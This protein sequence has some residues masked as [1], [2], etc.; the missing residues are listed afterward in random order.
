MEPIF[1]HTP[2]G[3][4]PMGE[5]VSFTLRPLRAEGFSAVFLT[6]SFEQDGGKNVSLPLPWTGLS[7]AHELFSASFPLP[8]D[9]TGLVWCSLTAARADGRATSFGPFQ[10]TVYDDSEAVPHW[11][12]RG[13][14]YQIFPDRFCRTAVPDPA[15]MPGGRTVH[16]NWSDLPDFLPNEQ[17]EVRNRDF[18]GGSLESI[19]RKIPYLKTLGVE[20]VYLC[21]IFEGAENHRYGTGDYEKIDPMLGTEEDFRA[22]C[23]ALHANGMKLLLDGVF[24]HTGFVSRYFNGDGS[25]PGLGAAQSQESSYY[26]WY[27]FTHWPD[28]YDSWWGVYSLPTV[29]K[30]EPT[31][32]DYIVRDKNSIARRWLRAGADGWRLDV[33][34]ELPDEF[35][36]ALH[37]AV[38]EE[39]P[40]AVLLGEVWEDGSNKIAYGV[41]RRHLWGRHL[42]G[43]MN[44]PLR[45]ALFAAIAE[46]D[47]SHLAQNEVLLAQNYP[48]F[49]RQNSMNFLG[50][51]DTVRVLSAMGALLT[52]PPEEKVPRANY[53][54]PPE[55]SASARA[56]VRI[57][58]AV[59]YA[60]PGSPTLYYGDEWGLEGFEDPLNRKTVPWGAPFDPLYPWFCALGALRAQNAPLRRG[61]L[62][63][64]CADGPLL[65]FSRTCG[66]EGVLC[67]ANLD[68]IAREVPLPDGIVP[69][70]VLLGKAEITD[71]DLPVLPPCSAALFSLAFP[72]E[73]T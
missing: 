13:V 15:G 10:L 49:A 18:F 16:E 68:E 33:A 56:L 66:T 64:L 51:H 25:Y 44:Y 28:G 22:L 29:R 67:C 35:I 5:T 52:S 7:G 19:R 58:A 59:L 39:N 41:R 32:L 45:D 9:Y 1:T 37:A 20:T 61:N 54:L 65:A 53:A 73:N 48:P 50:T 69:Q 31:Y 36:F 63:F 21:P 46:K 2:S 70:A 17:G 30:L 24:S 71:L 43:V 27:S 47:W 4:V 72:P 57:A 55:Y 11:F 3:A 23:E 12:G 60:L 62:Q 6:L 42:D 14:T 38:R 8:A 40:D 26:P 34:D